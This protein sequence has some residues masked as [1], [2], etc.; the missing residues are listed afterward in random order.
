LSLQETGLIPFKL[1][2]TDHNNAKSSATCSI[3]IH[4]VTGPIISV[5]GD[6]IAEADSATGAIV[7]PDRGYVVSSW[8]AVDGPLP[9]VNATEFFKCA[10]P[11]GAS[12]ALEELG[13]IDERQGAVD[14]V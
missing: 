4:D 7:G 14:G 12:F 13:G 1:T 3:L 9:L 8:D 6:F 10:P 2:V 11:P 5:P